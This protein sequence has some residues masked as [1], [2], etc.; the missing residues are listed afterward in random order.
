MTPQASFQKCNSHLSQL[1]FDVVHRAGTNN[2]ETGVQFRLKTTGTDSNAL[3]D[4][5]PQRTVTTVKEREKN[6]KEHDS[7]NTG[8]AV[9]TKIRTTSGY[10]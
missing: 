8:H 2:Q 4:K 5:V 6:H 9:P 1:E 7:Y 3:E 10:N